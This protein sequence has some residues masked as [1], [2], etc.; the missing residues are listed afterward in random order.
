MGEA[1]ERS[2]ATE[3]RLRIIDSDIHPAL[4]RESDLNPY[5]SARWQ[6][7]IAE[8]GKL[9]RGP[10]A[11]R[12][13]YP[14][15]M[16]N[17]ARRDAWPPSGAPPGSD[18]AFMRQQLLDKYDIETGILE[19]L[20]PGNLLR[21][22]DLAT[23]VCAAINDWQLETFTSREPRLRASI[24][25]AFEDAQ[26]SVREIEKR[27]ANPAFAQIQLTSR[28]LEPLG[29]QRYWPIFE[30]AEA[31]GLPIGLH[32]GGESG[33]APSAAGWPSFY[34]EDHHVLVHSMQTQAASLI[35][36]GVFERFPK[37]K[38]I[39]IEG[40]FAWLPTLGWRLDA[41]WQKM[42]SEVPHLKMPPSAYLH[43]NLW[44]ST[45]PMEEPER[46]DD[47]RKVI[48]WIGW[49]RIV[50]ASDYPHWDFDDPDRAFPC[51]LTEAERNMIL[52]GNAETLYKL[53]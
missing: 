8:Y 25:I 12:G 45:Q 33:H 36:E 19:P 53:G 24:Q 51:R 35:L 43:R 26:A 46:G 32:I 1:L 40:G 11:A 10:Y 38:I 44:V 16:P 52:R 31:L 42:R 47:L 9:A 3:T 22:T 13:T 39:M 15:F 48:D 49:D 27:A 50:F 21:N 34:V 5:L 30:A 4:A 29:R 41:H 2:T 28:S 17:T 20:F 23:A 14:R 37:L 18:L 6:N 7:H